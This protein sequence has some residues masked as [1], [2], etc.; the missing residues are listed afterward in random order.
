MPGMFASDLPWCI[1]NGAAD[2][3]DFAVCGR[4]MSR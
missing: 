3:V 4:T 2:L 1:I